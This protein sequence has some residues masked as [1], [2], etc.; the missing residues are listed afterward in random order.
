[1]NNGDIEEFLEQ[2]PVETATKRHT[3]PPS[4]DEDSSTRSKEFRIGDTVQ[5]MCLPDSK[6]CGSGPTKKVI[7]PGS[8]R[9][10]HDDRYGLT[11]EFRSIKTDDIIRFPDST[12]DFVLE[13]IKTFWTKKQK[14]KEMGHLFKRGILLWG[15]PGGG[16]TVTIALLTEDLIRRGGIVIHVTS[17]KLAIDA[18]ELIRKVQPETPIICVLEDIDEIINE[19]SEHLLLSLLDGENQVGNVVH[20]GTTNYPQFLPS[21][22]VNRPSRFDEIIK[23]GL[24]NSETRKLYLISRGIDDSDLK[25]WV[26]ETNGLSIAHLRELMIAVYCLGRNKSET[27]KRLKSMANKIKSDSELNVGYGD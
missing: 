26:K 17:P 4:V 24:P 23:V 22:F 2:I 3:K 16:K 7:Q 6:F 13:S 15:P 27:I 14:F 20:V 5:W 11:L 12:S 8:Y 1:M 18:L 19:Y 10:A 25:D 9:P 21:R